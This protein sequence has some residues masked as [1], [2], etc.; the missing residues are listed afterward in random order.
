M[1][2]KEYMYPS[3]TGNG[4]IK[5]WQWCPDDENVKAVIQM[6]HGM[7][8]HCGRYKNFIKAFTDLGY[9]VFMN[10]MA[11]HGNSVKDG[12]TLGYFGDKDGAKNIIRDAGKLTE[13]AKQEYPDK[14]F[15]IGGHSMGS[16]IMRCYINE[17]G[18]DGIDG[19]MFI[20]TAGPTPLA[21]AGKPIIKAVSAV[22]GKKHHSAFLNKISLG[23]YDKP[24]EHRTH[25]DWGIS[26]SAQVDEYVADPLCGFAFTAK[27]YDDLADLT[28]ACNEDFWFNNVAKDLPVI[29]ASGTMDPVG[30]YSNGVKAVYEKLLQTGHNNVTLK[31]YENK[32]HEILN[33][34]NKDEVYSDLNKWIEEKV[35]K[36]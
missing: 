16:L 26:D 21:K 24:F 36:A 27:G 15:I 34:V 35:L 5:A 10:D 7:A 8:E 29:L 28:I 3:C 13:I 31:L 33:E 1:K 19:A 30:D 20:G 23:A 6:H 2:T 11:G 4:E 9:A 14:K 25:Y 17:F 22:K 12:D 18:C 32:R